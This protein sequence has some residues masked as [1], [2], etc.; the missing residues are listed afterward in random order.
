MGKRIIPI[1]DEIWPES[2]GDAVQDEIENLITAINPKMPDAQVRKIADNCYDKLIRRLAALA[3]QIGT[4][5][6]M[7]AAT[8]R[9]LGAGEN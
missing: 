3:Y 8:K 5:Q 9:D 7:D 6:K 1:E 4:E 2:M